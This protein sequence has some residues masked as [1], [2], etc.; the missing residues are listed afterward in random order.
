MCKFGVDNTEHAAIKHVVTNNVNSSTNMEST[1]HSASCNTN[2]V[3]YSLHYSLTERREDQMDKQTLL[4]GLKKTTGAAKYKYLTTK[5][6]HGI[7]FSI[8]S[9]NSN[10][11]KTESQ[12]QPI[13]LSIKKNKICWTND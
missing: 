8:C 6:H 2:S 1:R 10:I 4:E 13:Q 12:V 3:V 7:N 9:Q 5:S 11:W